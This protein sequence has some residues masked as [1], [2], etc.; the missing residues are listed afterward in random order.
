MNLTIVIPFRNREAYLERTLSTLPS[1]LSLILV[2][3]GSTDGSLA[4]AQRFAENRPHTILAQES[5]EGASAARNRGLALCQT[6]WVYFFDSDDE[7]TS[8]P[9]IGEGEALDMVCFPVTMVVNGRERTRDFRLTARPEVHL[10][11]A[12]LGTQ[13]MIFRT[14]WLRSIGGWNNACPIWNDWELGLRALLAKPRLRWESQ[15]P[16]HRIYVHEDSITGPNYS[17]RIEGIR[18]TLQQ[19]YTLTAAAPENVRRAHDLRVAI[20]C[21]MLRRE[22]NSEAAKELNNLI[23]HRTLFSR[24]LERYVALGGRGAWRMALKSIRK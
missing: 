5:A 10:L 14:E 19:T 3:N 7:F 11:S 2:D 21:G 24:F 22:G 20:V 17:A 8:L 13:S 9:E 6:E 18:A 15:Q 23:R 16:R 1:S 12:M 4:I